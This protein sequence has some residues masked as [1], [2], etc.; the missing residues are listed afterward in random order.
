MLSQEEN[1]LLTRVGPGTPMGNVLR[2]YWVP[3]LISDELPEPDCAPIRVKLLGEELVA[4]RDSQGRVGILGAYCP[5]RGASLS[6]GRNEAGG[7]RCIYHGWKFD[8]AG[9]TLETPNESGV[10]IWEGKKLVAAYPTREA[11]GVVWAYLGPPEKT[12]PFPHYEWNVRTNTFAKKVL[13]ECNYLQSIEG[14]I[15]SSHLSWLHRRTITPEETDLAARDA[16]PR[17]ELQD[18]PYGFRYGAL[19]QADAG[20]QYVRITPFIMPWYT[21]V[22]FVADQVQA[23]HAWVPIDDTHNWVFT[24]NFT[25][26][27]DRPITEGT[28]PYDMVDRFHKL[29]TR[30][31]GHLQDRAAMRVDSWSGI[32]KIPDQDAGVQ[33]SMTR[34]FDRSTEHI[35][36]ADLAIVHMRALLLASIKAVQNGGDPVGVGSDFPADEIRCVVEVVPA[37]VRWTELGLPAGARAKR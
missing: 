16:A 6:Y 23:A 4:F 20:K 2:R 18:M 30:E 21:I 7:L 28:H 33:E 13:I 22:P 31:N 5:H 12:P 37:D 3:A 9:M 26:A 8:V 25:H 35:G 27:D 29:R 34:I 15:D 1:E 10:R 14:G 19:R 11:C 24:F 36:Q 17:I 32:P